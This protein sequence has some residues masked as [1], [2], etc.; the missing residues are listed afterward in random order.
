MS[1][2]E[3]EVPK[4]VRDAFIYMSE[5]EKRPD[6]LNKLVSRLDQCNPQQ[7]AKILDSISNFIIHSPSNPAIRQR[8]YDWLEKCVSP[9][10]STDQTVTSISYLGSMMKIIPT[11][12]SE[13]YDMLFSSSS[14]GTASLNIAAFFQRNPDF[15]LKMHDMTPQRLEDAKN[16]ATR[17]FQSK[18]IDA[19][20]LDASVVLSFAYAISAIG[21][22]NVE[23]LFNKCGIVKFGR[24]SIEDLNTTLHNLNTNARSDSRPVFISFKAYGDHNGALAFREAH[25]SDL[26]RF[27]RVIH[28]E[29][30][31]DTDLYSTLE[32]IARNNGNFGGIAFNAHAN[33]NGME[34]QSYV[35]DADPRKIIDANDAKPEGFVPKI[36]K[37]LL[38]NAAVIMK[39]CESG[40]GP[41]PFSKPLSA[42][43][44]TRVWSIAQIS[45]GGDYILAPSG[46]FGSYDFRTQGGRRATIRIFSR[47]QELDLSAPIRRTAVASTSRP[48]TNL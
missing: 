28:V 3:K 44:N 31:I 43:L 42:A 22:T 1:P 12:P 29:A 40:A 26:N 36:A 32:G 11:M 7:R 45:Y 20:Y 6:F 2:V 35:T 38:P 24:Y 14:V 27:Y 15:L 47:G 23:T 48:P 21:N 16:L 39:G 13:F 17:L 46:E 18:N 41:A 9:P 5:L 4:D 10:Y 34:L 30:G 8:F 33:P 19:K 25:L 37:L